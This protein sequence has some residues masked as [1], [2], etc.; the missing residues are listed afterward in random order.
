MKSS[1]LPFSKKG[2]LGINKNYIVIT[3]TVIAIKVYN[4]MLLNPI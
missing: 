2:D 3:L 1:S 4:A